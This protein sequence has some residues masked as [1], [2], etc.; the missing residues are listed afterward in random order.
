MMQLLKLEDEVRQLRQKLAE[1]NIKIADLRA[2]GPEYVSFRGGGSGQPSLPWVEKE[3]KDAYMTGYQKGLEAAPLLAESEE[4]SEVEEQ[5]IDMIRQR[6]DM[7]RQKYGT[8]MERTDWQET[9][10]LRAAQEEALD[11]AIYLQRLIRDKLS[12]CSA[13]GVIGGDALRCTNESPEENEE[14]GS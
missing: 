11:L 1:A 10:W 9:Q 13:R 6:R 3:L 5:V 2:G 7:G 4:S 12:S 14:P 8:T